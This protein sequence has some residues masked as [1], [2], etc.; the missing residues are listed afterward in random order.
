MDLMRLNKQILQLLLWQLQSLLL[1]G[2]AL[3]L[4]CVI[5]TNPIRD[6]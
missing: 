1:M 5:G 6:S 2:V 3:E 4:V